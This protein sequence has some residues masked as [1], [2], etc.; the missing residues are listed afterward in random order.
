[1]EREFLQNIRVGEFSLP[2]E[3]IDAILAENGKDMD[4]AAQTHAR[5]M[6]ALRV[7]SALETA[8][9][10][11]GG[12]NLKA[13]SA[14]LDLDSLAAGEDL[15]AAMEAAVGKLKQENDYLFESTQ[16]PPPYARGTGAR[17]SAPNTQP[18][19]LA[20][21]LREKYERK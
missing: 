20:G 3:I 18:A 8:V 6:S 13:I 12:R 21:A 15:A 11:A 4:N 19:T 1:M 2:E 10:K 9:T 7:Q 17:E 5:E 16:T 14:L